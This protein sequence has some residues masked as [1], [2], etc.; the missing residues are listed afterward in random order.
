[1]AMAA[2]LIAGL[3][4]SLADRPCSNLPYGT[5]NMDTLQ[6][7][8]CAGRRDKVRPKDNGAKPQF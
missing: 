1:M 4:G 8:F 7:S 6:A 2:S 3:C 5:A